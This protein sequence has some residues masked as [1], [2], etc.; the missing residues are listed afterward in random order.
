MNQNFQPW[1]MLSQIQMLKNK[2]MI[3]WRILSIVVSARIFFDSFG[4]FTRV[5]FHQS[6]SPSG[7]KKTPRIT[8]PEGRGWLN[9]DSILFQTIYFC[10]ASTETL[11]VIIIR[12][13]KVL[14]SVSF[15][16]GLDIETLKISVSVSV[17]K[18]RLWKI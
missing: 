9:F 1:E 15:S 14:V 16:L 8:N 12:L 11:Q 7:L 2:T 3:M 6:F 17:S 18:L 13:V 4:Q 5:W 10:A